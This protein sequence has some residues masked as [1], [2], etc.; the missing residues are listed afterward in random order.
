MPKG[1]TQCAAKGGKIR[2]ASGPSDRF[3]LKEGEYR[4]Y[5]YIGGKTCL[6]EKKKKESK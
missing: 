2:T 3:K 1:F 5:C 4:H 6:G